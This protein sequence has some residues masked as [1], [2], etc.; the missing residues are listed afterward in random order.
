MATEQEKQTIEEIE[1]TVEELKKKIEMLT[2]GKTDTSSEDINVDYDSE[3]NIPQFSSEKKEIKEKAI[4][5]LEKG[6]DVLSKGVESI[7]N[8]ASEVSKDPKVSENLEK[9]KA[10][11][12]SALDTAKE[13]LEDLK[14]NENVKNVSAKAKEIYDDA[15]NQCGK[16]FNDAKGAVEKNP[17]AKKLIDNVSTGFKV[18]SESVNKFLKSETVSKGIDTAKDVAV[19]GTQKFADLVKKVLKK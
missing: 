14:T 16:L 11:A 7:K 18:A 1:K 9:V 17:D 19:D 5:A 10:N 2:G 15:L 3:F 13:K 12:V 8:T 4:D 6:K